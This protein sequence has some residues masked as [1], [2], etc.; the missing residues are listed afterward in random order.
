[1]VAEGRGDEPAVTLGPSSSINAALGMF[2]LQVAI[3][4][5]Y[6]W[7]YMR[8]SLDQNEKYTPTKN[9]V[10]YICTWFPSFSVIL[11][12]VSDNSPP[13]RSLR[14]L[15]QIEDTVGCSTTLCLLFGGFLSTL[16]IIFCF[17]NL[18]TGSIECNHEPKENFAAVA[19]DGHAHHVRTMSRRKYDQA[20]KDERARNCPWKHD[21]YI[22]RKDEQMLKDGSIGVEKR[23]GD[24]VVWRPDRKSNEVRIS[25]Y[26]D[27]AFGFH[28]LKFHIDSEWGCLVQDGVPAGVDPAIPGMPHGCV[29]YSLDGAISRYNQATNNLE[30]INVFLP[31]NPMNPNE[32]GVLPL[33]RRLVVNEE[34]AS[35]ISKEVYQAK[36]FYIGFFLFELFDW[37]TDWG[38]YAINTKQDVT[39][40]CFMDEEGSSFTSF[41]YDEYVQAVLWFNII[42]TIVVFPVEI[43]MV[44]VR[45]WVSALTL[46][47]L[48]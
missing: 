3:C 13:P 45:L 34:D 21:A 5:G 39:L 43:A 33:S 41:K 6:G 40:K 35:K 48:R 46:D 47:T 30:F 42:G 31:K 1:M 36:W 23:A 14:F 29:G 25:V 22:T 9:R 10:R 32:Q 12:Q 2:I 19:K 15:V 37:M 8:D 16:I 38:F 20:S 17:M 7:A 28:V 11:V 24:F 4:I 27:E 26:Q 18:P 44:V